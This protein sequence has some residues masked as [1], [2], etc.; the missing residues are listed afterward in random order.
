MSQSVL[1]TFSRLLQSKR[2]SN[3][4]FNS[5]DLLQNFQ[6][7]ETCPLDFDEM[8]HILS[9]DNYTPDDQIYARGT[10]GGLG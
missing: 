9:N 10:Q 1:Q 7:L 3:Y 6:V 5:V 4:Y 2:T 8:L